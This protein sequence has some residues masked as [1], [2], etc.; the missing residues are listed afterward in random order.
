MGMLRF[1]LHLSLDIG[2]KLHLLEQATYKASHEKLPT[3]DCLHYT[4]GDAELRISLCGGDCIISR[5]QLLHQ[6]RGSFT[7][8]VKYLKVEL[9]PIG[10]KRLV[11]QSVSTPAMA[12]WCVK[13]KF[14]PVASTAFE[15]DGYTWGDY[16]LNLDPPSDNIYYFTI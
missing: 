11:I 10:V 3:E 6:R 4:C 2:R 5:V 8:L 16:V 1:P 9:P 13:N 12:S 15:A 14:T 7:E